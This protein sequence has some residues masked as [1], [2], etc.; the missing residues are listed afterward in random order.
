MVDFKKFTGESGK[1]AL[2][3]LHEKFNK[4]REAYAFKVK[5]LMELFDNGDLPDTDFI[6]SFLPRVSNKIKEDIFPLSDKE[7]AC[8]DKLFEE[9]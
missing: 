5:K 4:E 1:R 7:K 3:E 6:N 8:I 2:E 9:N